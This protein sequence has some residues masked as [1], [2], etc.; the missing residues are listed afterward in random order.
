[1]QQHFWRSNGF[2]DET[3]YLYRPQVCR[4]SSWIGEDGALKSPEQASYY[5]WSLLMIGLGATHQ[6]MSEDLDYAILQT[7]QNQS[8]PMGSWSIYYLLRERGF[9]VSAP[10]IGRRLRDLERKKLLGKKSVEGRLITPRGETL[11]RKMARDEQNRGRASKLLKILDRK[12]QK[13]V[14]DLLTVRRIIEAEG[15]GLAA[16][17]AT[18]M[19]I[20]KLEAIVEKQ[21]ESIK[22][23]EL[24]VKEDNN[25]HETIAKASGNKV[26]F[27]TVHLLRSQEWMNYA[28]TAIRTR[29]GTRL[30]V[31]HEKIISALKDRDTLSARRAMEKH[32]DQ[33]AT[34]VERYW[35]QF[36]QSELS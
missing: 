6:T 1:M 29:M 13:D 10:T 2:F 32:I 28:V 5:A 30:A 21:K 17:H 35:K 9:A 18:Q 8:Q 36:R 31:D 33:L 26:I 22:R 24:G 12:T 4:R 7:M 11:L 23:G 27:L 14:I 15:A 25:F 16:A 20:V 34:D 19:D 3:G